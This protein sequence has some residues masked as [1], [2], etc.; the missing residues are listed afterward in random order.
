M[1]RLLLSSIISTDMLTELVSSSLCI[2]PS[3]L[4]QCNKL[5]PILNIAQETTVNSCFANI[6]SICICLDSRCNYNSCHRTVLL[7]ERLSFRVTFFFSSLT[8]ITTLN[9]FFSLCLRYFSYQYDI[10]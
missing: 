3:L 1:G 8:M 4:V 10:H 7:N 6:S 5:T 9:I 2:I